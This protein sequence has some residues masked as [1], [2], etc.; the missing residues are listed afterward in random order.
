MGLTP[1][2]AHVDQHTPSHLDEAPSPVGQ[3]AWRH[4]GRLRNWQGLPVRPRCYPGYVPVW[5]PCDPGPMGTTPGHNRVVPVI[6]PWRR[7]KGPGSKALDDALGDCV[8]RNRP[9]RHTMKH[10]P[11]L[12]NPSA[13]RAWQGVVT[14]TSSSAAK[15]ALIGTHCNSSTYRCVTWKTVGAGNQLKAA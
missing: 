14:S 3:V 11:P 10:C 6:S 15:S 2:L 8:K 4:A 5:S 1:P 13:V 7:Q 12:S 9:L